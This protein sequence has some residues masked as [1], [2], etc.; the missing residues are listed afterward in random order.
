[1]HRHHMS[2]WSSQSINQSIKIAHHSG[3]ETSFIVY[4]YQKL[5]PNEKAMSIGLI[6]FPL[7]NHA[8]THQ[9]KQMC[10]VTESA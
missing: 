5:S 7:I 4:I 10:L 9:Q 2:V 8:H 3:G 6:S 1:M